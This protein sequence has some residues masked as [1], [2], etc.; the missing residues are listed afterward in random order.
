M[1]RRHSAGFG[2]PALR[3]LQ[4]PEEY[5]IP[6][7][8][9]LPDL[10]AALID[11]GRWQPVYR[12]GRR[13]AVEPGSTEIQP[14]DCSALPR[15]HSRPPAEPVSPVVASVVPGV[16]FAQQYL[17]RPERAERPCLPDFVELTDGSALPPAHSREVRLPVE[18]PVRGLSEVDSGC[19]AAGFP[20]ANSEPP[21]R[22]PSP[23]HSDSRQSLQTDRL[24]HAGWPVPLARQLPLPL[25]HR[26]S[27]FRVG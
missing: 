3:S 14:P 20:E 22:P 27:R 12:T 7:A 23:L 9:R 8:G 4:Y 13:P 24:P 17:L 25:V 18:P 1:L 5:Q 16:T 2:V 6:E 10:R 15:N 26:L 19:P 11:S 21:H